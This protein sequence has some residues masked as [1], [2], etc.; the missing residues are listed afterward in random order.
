MNEI[1]LIKRWQEYFEGLNI[2]YSEPQ[3]EGSQL[4]PILGQ[5]GGALAGTYFGGPAGGAAGSE[6]GRA[7][8][9]MLRK[10]GRTY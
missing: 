2:P 10:K 7:F 3:S 4:L 1:E 9:E 8:A 5:V 6:L